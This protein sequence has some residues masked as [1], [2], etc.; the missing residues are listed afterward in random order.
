MRQPSSTL[1]VLGCITTDLRRTASTLE[2]VAA[3]LNGVR[4]SGGTARE[5]IWRDCVDLRIA[6]ARLRY[7]A[8]RLLDDHA[9]EATRAPEAALATGALS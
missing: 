2:S 4:A 3:L 6:A 5:D 7:T 9:P 8:D 1:A